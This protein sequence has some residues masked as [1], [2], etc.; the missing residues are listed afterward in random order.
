MGVLNVTPDSFSDGGLFCD[1]DAAVRR[2]EEMAAQGAD[3]ID[4][5]P[6]S[7]RP[8]SDPVPSVEQIARI[9]PIIAGIRRSHPRLPIS[10]DT[11][12][13]VVAAEAIALGADIIN[14]V[15]A[16]RDDAGMSR[17]AAETGTPVILMHMRGRP[18]TMQ[19]DPASPAYDDVVNDIIEF[20]RERIAF[21]VERGISRERLAVD[22]GLGFGKTTAHNL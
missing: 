20:L 19:A 13:A 5:G 2:A 22:P 16:L 11:R 4:V 9:R 15:S 1:T 3:L 12:S 8:G 6:E 7:T 21:A 17:L 10:I 14:D 18:K